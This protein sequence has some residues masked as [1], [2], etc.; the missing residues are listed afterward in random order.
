MT[1]CL[2]KARPAIYELNR[3]NV[4][5]GAVDNA[6]TDKPPV[7]LMEDVVVGKVSSS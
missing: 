5:V 3:R 2:A 7:Q 6:G 1:R 4:A